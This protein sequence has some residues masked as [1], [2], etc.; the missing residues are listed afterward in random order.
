MNVTQT[1]DSSARQR[2]LPGDPLCEEVFTSCAVRLSLAGWL[3]SRPPVPDSVAFLD[4]LVARS[5]RS[6]LIP[7]DPVECLALLAHLQQRRAHEA[8]WLRSSGSVGVLSV[9]LF[10]RV[11]D[12]PTPL[13]CVDIHG[14]LRWRQALAN[15]GRVAA[16]ARGWLLADQLGRSM[17]GSWR[18]SGGG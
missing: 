9:W 18:G 17:H 14:E 13:A 11:A 10:L 2:L 12:L 8:G 1:G 16:A 4:G 7:T 3:A 5:E 6:S 15:A